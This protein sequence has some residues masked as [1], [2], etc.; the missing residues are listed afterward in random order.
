MKRFLNSGYSVICLLLLVFS[1]K[2]SSTAGSPTSGINSSEQVPSFSGT[3]F[4]LNDVSILMKNVEES[5][6][7]QYLRLSSKSKEGPILAESVFQLLHATVN[8]RISDYNSWA[9]AALRIDNCGK[10]IAQAPCE[11]QIRLVFQPLET[12]GNNV[13]MFADEGIHVPFNVDDKD[14]L[15][16]FQ[17]FLDLKKSAQIKTNGPLGEHPVLASEGMNG[18]FAK[19]LHELVLKYAVT[20]K[21]ERVAAMNGPSSSRTTGNWVFAVTTPLHQGTPKI[22]PI[23]CQDGSNTNTFHNARGFAGEQASAQPEKLTG[24]EE[25]DATPLVVKD[26]SMDSQRMIETALR[27][28]NPDL[29]F[30]ASTNCINCH[31]TS[32]RLEQVIGEGTSFK[33][34]GNPLRYK[35]PADVSHTMSDAALTDKSTPWAIRAF[36]WGEG[37]DVPGIT[38]FTLNDTIRVAH[39][40]NDLIRNGSLKN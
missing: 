3:T 13:T 40:L 6:Q 30:F 14:R 7:N 33:Q 26:P 9:L 12:V 2:H 28:N 19:K 38:L 24:C 37:G 22:A 25:F 4:D 10:L 32:R 5:T 18:P 21:S 29:T 17:D 1:C 36:G 39:E 20:S 11:A 23:P 8:F 31:L 27:I 16:F 34:D 35:L 15:A